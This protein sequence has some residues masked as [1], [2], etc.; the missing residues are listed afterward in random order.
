MTNPRDEFDRLD[1]KIDDLQSTKGVIDK[2]ISYKKELEEIQKDKLDDNQRLWLLAHEASEKRIST[3]SKD[4][5]VEDMF[6][7]L[8][9]IPNE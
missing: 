9:F 6:L 2:I 3:S 8:K 1:K 5:I 7:L 4:Q